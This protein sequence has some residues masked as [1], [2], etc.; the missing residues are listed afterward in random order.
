[1]RRL[2]TK[3]NLSK[4]QIEEIKYQF[5]AAC[6][7]ELVRGEYYLCWM[8]EGEAESFAND[9]KLEFGD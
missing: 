3:A 5:C 8:C 1:M 2:V 9:M 4:E 6:P 7:N